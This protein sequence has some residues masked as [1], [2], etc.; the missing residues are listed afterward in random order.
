LTKPLNLRPCPF[1]IIHDQIGRRAMGLPLHRSADGL[2]IGV[3]FAGRLGAEEFMFSLADQL[4]QVQP[5]FDKEW[6][7]QPAW[8][9]GTIRSARNESAGRGFQ[10]A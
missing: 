5:R 9:G 7:L 8:R 2:P 10:E 6:P 4:E 1:T 3:P